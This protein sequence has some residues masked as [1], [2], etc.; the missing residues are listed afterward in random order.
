MFCIFFNTHAHLKS[1]AQNDFNAFLLCFRWYFAVI[2]VSGVFAVTFSVIFAY[3]ADITQEHERSMAYG[4][5]RKNP[6][7]RHHLSSRPSI[8][9][10]NLSV[11]F[12]KGL[13]H[14]CGESRDQPGHRRV[15]E[16]GLWRHSGSGSGFCHRYA[17][18]LLHP[19]G[20][21][22]VTSRKDEAGFLGRPHLMGTS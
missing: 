3:V 11:P 12:S 16:S 22:R 9:A 8:F 21:A 1:H 18:H 4:M 5:V 15:S 20:R 10:L 6:S 17:G 7:T 13:C 19:G 14:V 2:S